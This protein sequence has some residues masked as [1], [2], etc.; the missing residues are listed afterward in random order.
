MQNEQYPGHYI[1]NGLDGSAYGYG[2]YGVSEESGLYPLE[3]PAQP[4]H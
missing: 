1:H 2:A 4:M 3:L